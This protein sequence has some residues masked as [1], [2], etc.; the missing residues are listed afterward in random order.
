MLVL[1]KCIRQAISY[2]ADVQKVDAC[3]KI[4]KNAYTMVLLQGDA[5]PGLHLRNVG[6]FLDRANIVLI[7]VAQ[8]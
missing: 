1:N 2:R 8:I 6:N 3:Q 7:M 4:K 5:M